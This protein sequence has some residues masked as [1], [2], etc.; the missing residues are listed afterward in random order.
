MRRKPLERANESAEG[1]NRRSGTGWMRWYRTVLT[2]LTAL[3]VVAWP[4]LASA[5]SPVLTPSA[6]ERLQQV[7]SPSSAQ[8]GG[9]RY[10]SV[11]IQSN[12]AVVRFGS[13]TQ[14]VEVRLHPPGSLPEPATRTTHFDVAVASPGNNPVEQVA[15]DTATLLTQ[16]AADDIWF[17]PEARSPPPPAPAKA[18]EGHVGGPTSPPPNL[19]G[20]VW[21]RPLGGAVGVALALLLGAVAAAVYF[22]RARTQIAIG[23]VAFLLLG[24]VVPTK[25][26]DE[27]ED[28]ER[29]IFDGQLGWAPKGT[30]PAQAQKGKPFAIGQRLQTPRT[31]GPHVIA[32]GDSVAFGWGLPE[33]EGFVAQL[34]QALTETEVV[35]AAVS[36]YAPDQELLY[37]ERFEH[38]LSPKLIVV[39]VFLGND[40][41]GTAGANNYGSYKPQFRVQ[42]GELVQV[43]PTD[44]PFN[45]VSVLSWSALLRPFWVAANVPT[46][47]DRQRVTQALDSVCRS[48]KLPD[49]ETRATLKVVFARLEALAQRRGAKLLTVLLPTAI[50]LQNA[51]Q[52]DDFSDEHWKAWRNFRAI[53][54]EGSHAMLDLR[55]RFRAER[56]WCRPTGT[57]AVDCDARAIY[58]DG[59][60][61]TAAAGKILAGWLAEHIRSEYDLR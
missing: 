5:T 47:D 12:Q 13:D 26:P 31:R 38:L 19:R 50:L 58:L 2:G 54:T 42:N 52:A 6:A 8:V 57:D 43:N 60:H 1:A 24:S 39:F 35:N 21:F 56:R 55:E 22:V 36:G 16:L 34:G 7:F 44:S 53:L 30:P 11:R 15:K 51:P 46:H 45:C 9:Q 59:G 18:P 20:S 37:L 3:I 33:E 40:W 61:F 41:M 23:T 32:L 48:P 14:G 49:H 10:H 28:S 25:R 27:Q 29:L 4:A 17:V